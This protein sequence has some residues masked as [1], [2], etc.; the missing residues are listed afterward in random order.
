MPP[1]INRAVK[2]KIFQTPSRGPSDTL[3]APP[4]TADPDDEKVSPFSTPPSEP[5]S[6]L[7][8]DSP[9]SH[10]RLFQ[11]TAK[12][13]TATSKPISPRGSEADNAPRIPPR[14]SAS[15]L[16]S[17]APDRGR[18]LPPSLPPRRDVVRPRSPRPPPPPPDLPRRSNEASRAIN[19]HAVPSPHE[20]KDRS[21]SREGRALIPS[22]A[23]PMRK[24]RPTSRRRRATHVSRENQSGNRYTLPM[25]RTTRTMTIPR[26]GRVSCARSTFPTRRRP[27]GGRR[28]SERGRIEIHTKYENQAFQGAVRGCHLH[29]GLFNPGVEHSDWR[30]IDE[31]QPRRNDQGNGNRFQAGQGTPR[32]TARGCGLG[33]T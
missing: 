23:A 2:P 32:T 10:S 30:A 19:L 24:K 13:P 29:Y 16:I 11:T 21:R 20:R 26:K 6:P 18:E 8:L 9:P 31:H 25:N 1:P 4:A 12:L 3:A 17:D 28:G 15:D 5:E 22:P 7:Q 14:S 33:P 27:T